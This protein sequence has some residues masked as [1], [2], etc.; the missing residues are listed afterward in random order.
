MKLSKQSLYLLTS[1][2]KKKNILT[3]KLI[4][5]EENIHCII[6]TAVQRTENYL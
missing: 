5:D 2:K 1:S 4:T 6:I 3:N